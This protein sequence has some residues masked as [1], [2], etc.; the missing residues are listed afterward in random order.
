MKNKT[1]LI[2]FLSIGMYS[3]IS[4]KYI[5]KRQSEIATLDLDQSV[6]NYIPID[7]AY[8]HHSFILDSTCALIDKKEFS[9]LNSYL[10]TLQ[11]E[12]ISTS[13]YQLSQ[14][15]LLISRKEYREALNC[16]FKINESEYAMVK[17][18]LTIDLNYEISRLNNVF[19]YTT[20]LKSYQDLIDKYPH[21]P[22]LRK[23]VGIR[24]RYLRYNY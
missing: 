18:L 7:D 22:S 23:I 14:S 4:P 13:D 3:C 20:F 5:V 11:K 16:L 24:L 1:L 12:G 17:D 2:L 6:T 21:N 9:K 15:L 8:L 19:D 10:M